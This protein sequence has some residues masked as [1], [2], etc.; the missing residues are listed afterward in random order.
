MRED[1]KTCNLMKIR[2]VVHPI[3]GERDQRSRANQMGSLEGRKEGSKEANFVK[4]EMA[5]HHQLNGHD[6]E[7][8]P[9]DS[10][11]QGSMARCSPR[12]RKESNTT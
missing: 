4:E 3:L 8:T 6:F 11:G 2:N 5:K 12:G 10:G 9:G 7:Q 1:G